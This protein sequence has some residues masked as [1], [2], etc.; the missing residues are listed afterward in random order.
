MADLLA[1]RMTAAGYPALWPVEGNAVFVKFPRDLDRRLRQ[2]GASYHPWGTNS[3]PAGI[4]IAPDEVL[5][6]LVT[7]FATRAEDI[8][9]FVGVV[10]TA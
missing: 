5:V 2:A 9:E 8:E 3:L 7:S 10:R 6:R 1:G 4:A